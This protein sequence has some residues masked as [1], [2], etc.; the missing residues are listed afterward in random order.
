MNLL[1][2]FGLKADYSHNMVSFGYF[3]S[4]SHDTVLPGSYFSEFLIKPDHKIVVKIIG[5]ATVIIPAIACN[6]LFLW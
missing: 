2:L 1:T 3:T 5:D 4:C 6:F